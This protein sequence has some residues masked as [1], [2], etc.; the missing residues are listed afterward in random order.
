M[1]I[2]PTAVLKLQFAWAM[3]S[4]HEQLFIPNIKVEKTTKCAQR[5]KATNAFP[6][7]NHKELCS[8]LILFCNS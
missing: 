6:L 3:A 4:C 2:S 1:S 7:Y 8:Q 5:V